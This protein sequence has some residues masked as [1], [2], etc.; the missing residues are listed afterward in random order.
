[1]NEEKV[2]T[3]G[4]VPNPAS[5]LPKVVGVIEEITTK[6]SVTEKLHKRGIVLNVT[7]EEDER[8]SLLF[9]EVVDFGEG[10]TK[11]CNKLNAYKVG[12][13][14]SIIFKPESRSSVKDGKTT[15]FV[16]MML[17]VITLVKEVPVRTGG[18][19][20]ATAAERVATAAVVGDE[21]PF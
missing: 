14:V 15:W 20:V 7:K 18:A 11:N 10:E 2:I 6:N 8:P 19:S 17:K 4:F 3:M 13:T 9:I 21:P 5:N 12:D 16:S 1:M